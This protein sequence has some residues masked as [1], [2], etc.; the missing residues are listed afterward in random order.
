MN[1]GKESKQLKKERVSKHHVF[2]YT[3]DQTH[4]IDNYQSG[5]LFKNGNS[6]YI[7]DYQN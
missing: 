6:V 1:I 5:V 2:D 7:S 3:I 4:K